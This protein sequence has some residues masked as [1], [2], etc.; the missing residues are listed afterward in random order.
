MATRYLSAAETAKLVRR[1][2]AQSFPGFKFSV[3]SKT[4]S[5]GASIDIGWADGPRAKEVEPIAKRYEGSDFDGMIDLKY[6][7]THYLR[8]D[9][10]VMVRHDPGT[11]GNA[12]SIPGD[13]NRMFEE[14]MPDDV[15][16]VHFGADFIFCQREISDFDAEYF[17]AV[18]WLYS[19]CKMETDP[20]G[21][22][23]SDRFGGRWV[24]DIARHLVYDSIKGEDWQIA[25]DRL[26]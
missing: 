7:M 5:G 2:L 1:A 10:S 24:G 20:T 3:R 13:D 11:L 14:L 23:N 9:G 21:N 15:E 17:S 25:F 6:S 22:P 12:G 19:H 8:P 4:Y 26:Y 18:Q 16:A